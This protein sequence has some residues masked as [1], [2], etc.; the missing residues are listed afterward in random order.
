MQRNINVFFS[1]DEFTEEQKV[2][3]KQRIQRQAQDL[4]NVCVVY[5]PDCGCE[6][7]QMVVLDRF[8]MSPQII[9]QCPLC[10][11]GCLMEISDPPLFHSEIG[12]DFTL[13]SLKTSYITDTWQKPLL[14]SYKLLSLID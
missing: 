9:S 5:R 6:V 12:G 13:E 7:E 1:K 8:P 2:I 4:I 14:E 11:K 10:K 3:I